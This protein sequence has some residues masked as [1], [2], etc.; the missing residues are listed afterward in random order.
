MAETMADETVITVESLK[1]SL[2]KQGLLVHKRGIGHLDFQFVYHGYPFAVRAQTE[3]NRTT[4]EVRT[5]LGNMP[6][7]AESR[8]SRAAAAR[9]LTAFNKE[10]GLRIMVSHNQRLILSAKIHNNETL[11]P[12]NL[13]TMITI[14][15][16]QATPYLDLLAEY[17][18]PSGEV[19][20]GVQGTDLR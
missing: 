12:S 14:M 1:E 19:I 13:L 9:I 15:L 11:S 8:A 17:V 16:L 18:I 3:E 20:D 2:T 7:S 4:I 6:Y 10:I 5:I